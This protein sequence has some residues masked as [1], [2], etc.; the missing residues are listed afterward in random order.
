MTV[1][2]FSDSNYLQYIAWAGHE[3]CSLQS[4]RFMPSAFSSGVVRATNVSLKQERMY[5]RYAWAVNC[6]RD[7]ENK[8]I[9][10]NTFTCIFLASHTSLISVLF[11]RCY[12]CRK[13]KGAKPEKISTIPPLRKVNKCVAKC[14][15]LG[16]PHVIYDPKWPLSDNLIAEVAD[17]SFHFADSRSCIHE[18]PMITTR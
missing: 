16:W 15:L 6:S 5:C 8:R 7:D 3:I 12:F 18:F 4:W 1:F 13:K 10:R 2:V 9:S 14:H 17:T 11:I